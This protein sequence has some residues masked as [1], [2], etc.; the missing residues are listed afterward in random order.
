M[1]VPEWQFGYSPQWVLHH[2]SLL[3]FQDA[4]TLLQVLPPHLENP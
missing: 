2:F 4:Q 3:N 1:K